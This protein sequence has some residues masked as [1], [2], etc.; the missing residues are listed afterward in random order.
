MKR[1]NV[2]K[3]A[4]SKSTLHNLTP[5]AQRMLQGGSNEISICICPSIGASCNGSDKKACCA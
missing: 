1:K 5:K 4:I 3:L 2:K